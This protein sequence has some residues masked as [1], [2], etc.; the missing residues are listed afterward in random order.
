MSKTVVIKETVRVGDTLDVTVNATLEAGDS[1]SSVTWSSVRGGVVISGEN[2][3]SAALSAFIEC[4]ARGIA[5]ARA[6][7]ETTGGQK[8]SVI[9]KIAVLDLAV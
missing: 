6:L 2:N 8:R 7:V 5:F 9:I 1:I 3:S 4:P